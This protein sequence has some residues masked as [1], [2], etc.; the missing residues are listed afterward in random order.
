METVQLLQP[1]QWAEQTFGQVQLRDRRRTRRAVKAASGMARDPAASLPKQQQSWKA[2]KA[3]YLLLDEADVTFEALMDPHWQQTRVRM[4]AEALV[5]LVQDTTTLELSDHALMTGLGPIDNTSG[6]GL[7][8]QTVL[9][10]VPETLAVLGCLVQQPF[11]R[12]PAPPKEQRYQRRHREQ[13]ETDIWMRLVEQVGQ[14]SGSGLLVHVGDRTAD[15]LPFI[16]RCLST[17]THFVVRAAQNRRV[18]TEENAVGHLLDQVRA[19]PSQDQHRFE[20][21]ASHGRH[22]RQ[23]TLQISFGPAT[24]LPP[25]NDPRGS[26]E[27]LPVWMV[28]VWETEPPPGEAALE[29]ILVT[30]LETQTCAQAWLQAEWYRCRWAVEEDHQCLKTGCRVEERY[31]HTAE[32]LIR[33]LGLLSPVAVRRLAT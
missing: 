21:P 20:V 11:V 22:A 10:V 13:R 25:W 33:L 31:V 4:Q 16:R 8:L 32:R 5:L 12:I 28:R 17:Q 2:V 6:Q 9:A 27:P 3:L 1:D 24:L 29:W 23:T 18:P 26:T 19:W 30:S 7:L 15:M 14:P